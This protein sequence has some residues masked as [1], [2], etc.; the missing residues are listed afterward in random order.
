MFLFIIVGFSHTDEN[1]NRNCLEIFAWN[2]F[3]ALGLMVVL[4]LWELERTHRKNK[5]LGAKYGD[6]WLTGRMPLNGAGKNLKI[7]SFAAN[8]FRSWLQMQG[9]W[10]L[11]WITSY[12]VS[13][14]PWTLRVR[15]CPPLWQSWPASPGLFLLHPQTWFPSYPGGITSGS[16]IM[17]GDLI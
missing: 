13:S 14:L 5:L 9:K 1:R 11:L 12:F 7:R 10:A 8:I 4:I 6:N 3:K 16:R 15:Q 17:S 2:I